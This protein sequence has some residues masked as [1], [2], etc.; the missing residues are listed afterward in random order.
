M[1]PAA[2]DLV[3]FGIPALALFAAVGFGAATRLARRRAPGAKPGPLAGWLPI[4]GMAVWLSVTGLAAKSGVLS[5]F[6]LKPPPLA[7]LM[8]ATLIV[9]IGVGVSSTGRLLSQGVPLW[10]LVLGQGFRLPLEL[11]MHQAA[12]EG[13]M[14]AQLSFGVSG[15]AQVLGYNYDI[16]VGASAIVI[17]LLAR[18]HKAPRLLIRVWN[19]AGFVSLSIIAIVAMLT[20]PMLQFFGPNALNTWVAYFP[21]VWLP[22]SCV[23]FALIGHIAVARHLATQPAQAS[24]TTGREPIAV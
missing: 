10:L 6:D 24:S 1:T 20:S 2:S 12:A 13:V 3:L 18:K 17:G 19:V 23:A 5:R 14:P 15:P 11:V 21:Y 7:L 9:A 8:A 4:A 22:A 16:I